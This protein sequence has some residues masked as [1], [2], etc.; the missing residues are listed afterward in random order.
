LRGLFVAGT[1]TGV[2]KTIVAGAITAAL[3]AQGAEVRA[4]KP[5]ITGLEE[6]GPADHEV[7]ARAGGHEPEEVS[8]V[9]YG[10]PLSPHLAAELA[11]RPIDPATLEE[12]IADRAAEAEVVVVEGVGGLLV[13]LTESYD[14]RA[15]ARALALPLLV[16]A[17]P[18]LGTINHTLLTLEV[19]RAAG[20]TVAAVV[21][22]PWPRAPDTIERSNRDTIELLGRVEVATLPPIERLEP[23]LM[24]A[25]GD[26]LPIGRWIGAPESE[27]RGHY[28]SDRGPS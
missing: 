9:S 13:P 28:G 27:G 23:E 20:L 17:R 21:L 5:V 26:E 4:L 24:A 18:G 11:E 10:P 6:A 12:T 8:I 25:A 2:G 1:D 16:V 14:V 15:L 3:R 7:L 22:T 19:A